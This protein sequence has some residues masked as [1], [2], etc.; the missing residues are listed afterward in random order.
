MTDT[1]APQP[2]EPGEGVTPPPA[3]PTPPAAPVPPAPPAYGTPGDS[4]PSP[5]AP[6]NPYQSPSAAQS[7][8]LSAE[9]DKRWATFAHF[10]GVLS[11]LAL[12]TGWLGLLAL[13]PALVIYLVY[14]KRGAHTRQEAK[15]A[16]NFQITVIGALI[17]WTILTIIISSALLFNI[18]IGGY[19]VIAGILGFIS[20]LIV[21]ADIVFSII[22]GVK[23]NGGGSYRYPVSIRFIK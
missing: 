23:V 4:A 12:F 5:A 11:V 19:L 6:A 13:V 17:V 10:G 14:G 20:W 2:G 16:L 9:D 7:G 3:P 8:P 15:E 21:I 22:G 1:S 18:G